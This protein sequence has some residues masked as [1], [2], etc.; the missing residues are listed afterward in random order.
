MSIE[1]GE[2]SKKKVSIIKCKLSLF[3]TCYSKCIHAALLFNNFALTCNILDFS[4]KLTIRLNRKTTQMRFIY[5]SD[6]KNLH[7]NIYLLIIHLNVGCYNIQKSLHQIQEK[8]IQQVEHWADS[9]AKTVINKKAFTPDESLLLGH[10]LNQQLLF[11]KA[12]GSDKKF[13]ELTSSNF[14]NLEEVT[15]KG[16]KHYGLTGY[17]Y[18]KPK[19]VFQ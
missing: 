5:F 19:F 16:N 15:R 17:E 14:N 2:T 1:Q 4:F 6:M 10:K 7:I 9:L 18:A 12:L 3:S 8:E 11:Y 13:S